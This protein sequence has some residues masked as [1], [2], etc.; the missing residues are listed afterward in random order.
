MKYVI[1]TPG[2]TYELHD[3]RSAL[4]TTRRQKMV[5]GVVSFDSGE[6]ERF[7]RLGFIDYADS[8]LNM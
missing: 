5:M 4:L 3:L 2:M 8:V 7:S 1:N 6:V